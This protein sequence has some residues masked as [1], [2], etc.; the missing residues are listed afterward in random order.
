MKLSFKTLALCGAVATLLAACGGGDAPT[1]TDLSSAVTVSAASDTTLNGVYSTTNTGLSDV[2]KIRRIGATD[3][4]EFTFD[5][6]VKTGNS[7]VSM[8]G[9]VDYTADT[10]STLLSGLAVGINNVFYSTADGSGTVVDRAAN[11]V[12]FT[13]KTLNAVAAGTSTLVVTGSLPMRGN[14]PSGC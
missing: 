14:R 9:T 12:R 10:S 5:A 2:Q 3:A 1:T 13:A 7:T 4:C 8:T 11:Q 6:L